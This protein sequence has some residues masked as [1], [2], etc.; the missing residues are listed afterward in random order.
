MRN[1]KDKEKEKDIIK[2]IFSAI[3]TFKESDKSVYSKLIIDLTN[4]D[5]NHILYAGRNKLDE[6]II[7]VRRANT[8]YLFSRAYNTIMYAP[9]LLFHFVDDSHIHIDDVLNK[10]HSV[11][12]G[13]ILMN[14]LLAYAEINQIK[15]ISGDLSSV[16][17]DHKLRRDS[18]YR[19]FGFNV[20]ERSIIKRL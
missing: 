4:D 3:D 20:S 8:I 6:F 9:K 5:V 10:H 2:H 18:Y 16:D 19:K 15:I 7:A 1:N 12:N 13:N 14:A 17:D 11:G